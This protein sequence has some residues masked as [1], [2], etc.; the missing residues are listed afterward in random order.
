MANNI[1]IKYDKLITVCGVEFGLTHMSARRRMVSIG[2]D[3]SCSPNYQYFHKSFETI[4]FHSV[5]N[6]A[7]NNL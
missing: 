4:V 2:E 6:F 3:D 7:I 1:I 5:Y